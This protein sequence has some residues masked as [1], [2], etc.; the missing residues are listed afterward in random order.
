MIGKV[1]KVPWRSVVTAAAT[2]AVLS[3]LMGVPQAAAASGASTSQEEPLRIVTF[4]DKCLTVRN[5]RSANGA[6]IEQYTCAGLNEQRFTF[7]QVS[8]GRYEIKTFA[9]R[10]L[11]VW[12]ESI[13]NSALIVQDPCEGLAAQKFRILWLGDGRVEIHTFADKCF[14]VRAGGT[15]N[16]TLI[17]QYSC[18]NAIQQK[19]RIQAL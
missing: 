11:T 7:V 18:V 17:D 16:G 19:F 6:P 10:C 14:T 2:A 4:V 3:P 9:N 1:S 15:A 12:N 13:A 8:E 5:E